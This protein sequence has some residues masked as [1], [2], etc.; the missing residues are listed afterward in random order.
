M[1]FNGLERTLDNSALMRVTLPQMY[2]NLA[3]VLVKM[4]SLILRIRFDIDK[5]KEI[6]TQN[7]YRATVELK[8]AQSIKEGKT[9]VEAYEGFHRAE[10][11]S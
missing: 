9:W 1:A 5:I 3:Y 6:Y 10:R 7:E 11:N 4:N 2:H 8:M